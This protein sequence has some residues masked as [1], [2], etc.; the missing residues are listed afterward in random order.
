MLSL[1]WWWMLLLL[2]LPLL[3]RRLLPRSPLSTMAISV[4]LL[5][6]YPLSASALNTG[7]TLIAQVCLWTFWICIVL[8]A[9]R[10]F[11]LG[12]PIT[13]TIS[14]RDLILAIDISGSMHEVDMLLNA[15]PASRIDVLKLIASEFI[16]RRKGDR[17]GLILFG[18]RAYTYVPLTYDRKTLGEL[19]VEI[20]AGLAGRLTA[21][22]DAIGIAVK[23][24]NQQQ[25]RHK[26]LILVTDGSNTAG[27]SDP[28][29]SALM[30]QKFGMTIHTIGI[31]NDEKELRAMLDSQT[32]S[33]GTALNDTLLRQIS[34]LSGGHYFRARDTQSLESIYQ[35][36]DEL[37]PVP[38]DAQLHRP[39]LDL[40]HWPLMLGLGELFVFFWLSYFQIDAATEQMNL[41][42]SFK[43]LTPGWLLLLPLA[44]WLV[45]LFTRFPHNGS[46]WS[47][48][49]DAKLLPLL[50]SLRLNRKGQHGLVLPL[51]V[52]CTIAII[53]LAGPSWQN[54]ENPLLKSTTARVLILDLSRSMLVE[55]IKPNRLTLALEALRAV[56]DSDFD[57][58]TGL[59]VFAGDSFV[60]S[61][62]T[63]DVNTL[64]E[65]CAM[66]HPD[67]MPVEGGRLDLA[68]ARASALLDASI[69][70][71]GRLIVFSDGVNDTE[72]AIRAT[73][74][75]VKLGHQL[76][77]VAVG[78]RQGAPLKYNDGS[79]KR[80]SLGAFSLAKENFAALESIAQLGQG[81]FVNL[82]DYH[83]NFAPMIIELNSNWLAS[84]QNRSQDSEPQSGLDDEIVD[85][86][87]RPE[88]GGFWLVWLMLP[89]A[90]LLFRQNVLWVVLIAVLAPVSNESYAMDFDA[91]WMNAEQQAFSAYQK[92]DYAQ[93][94]KLSSDATLIGSAL[95][96]SQN[97]AAGYEVFS[98]QAD[99]SQ[100]FYNRAN[101]LAFE[102]KFDLAVVAYDQ[103]LALNPEFEEAIFNKQLIEGYLA[104]QSAIENQDAKLSDDN[105]ELTGE[106]PDQPV[107][108]QSEILDNS[109]IDSDQ[110]GV[111]AG[112]LFYEGGIVDEDPFDGVEIELEPLMRRIREQKGAPNPDQLDLWAES[113]TTSPAD[114][115]Q[116]SFL[117]DYKRRQRAAELK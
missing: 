25:S 19:L 8:A 32:I 67:L 4:P 57:G 93:A 24:L 83:R 22:G 48:V 104:D 66:L 77:M 59:V 101:A 45:W 11:W 51:M 108:G 55:D 94:E 12:E 10:P 68:I 61:P 34:A 2:P 115:F 62:L 111:G 7:G 82:S 70:R 78:S 95:F 90:L 37:E 6:R 80:D 75:G 20:S 28:L 53:A 107:I 85:E 43:F 117:R 40:F 18:T 112:S 41:I 29:D 14:G 49:C 30:A 103:A 39:K 65:F 60:V 1:T 74:D 76:S 69:T 64:L 87:T 100:S 26:V 81:R 71:T 110:A 47:Q 36:L 58:E 9:S 13:R 31:G 89:L 38:L 92:G 113:M 27:I 88:N 3:A 63:H 106:S 99:S 44:W 42:E 5:S 56:I 16:D 116:R 17:I 98:S 54:Q 96:Q 46:M 15:K 114:L 52:I 109:R 79:L 86:G 102:Q 84:G 73:R 35:I 33:P 72:N 91:L 23:I 50:V 97:Y 105:N 21:I